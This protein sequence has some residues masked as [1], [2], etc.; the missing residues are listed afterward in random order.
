M[1]EIKY[2][3]IRGYDSNFDW[4]GPH[5]KPLL[6]TVRGTESQAY[7]YAKKLPRFSCYTGERVLEGSIKEI[8]VLDIT[9]LK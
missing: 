9:E 7:A 3:E 2:F 8:T 6:A 5:V 4:C 1:E